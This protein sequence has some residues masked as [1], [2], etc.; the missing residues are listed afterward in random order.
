M[1]K[2]RQY[3]NRLSLKKSL[4]VMMVSGLLIV[5]VLSIGIVVFFD[6]IKNNLD[7]KRLVNIELSEVYIGDGEY[8]LPYTTP[9]ELYAEIPLS[10]SETILYYFSSFMM[11]S[12]PLL[13]IIGGL[14]LIVYS[15]YRLKIAQPLKQLNDGIIEITKQNLDFKLEI[16]SDDELGALCKTFETMREELYQN[17]LLLYQMAQQRQ[18]LNLS[19]SHDLRTPI[20]ILKGYLDFL[21]QNLERL[22]LDT[23][24]KT[25]YSMQKASNRLARYVECIQDI[26]KVEEIAVKK[27]QIVLATLIDDLSADFNTNALKNDKQLIINNQTASPIINSDEEIIFKILENILNNAFRFAR[28]QV[29]ITISEDD[30]CLFFAIKDDGTGFSDQDLQEATKMYYHSNSNQGTFGI[31][32]TISSILSSKLGGNLKIANQNGALVTVKIKKS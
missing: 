10:N 7:S 5:I 25:I 9:V 13:I 18:L 22:P 15:Y 30:N 28:K 3:F 4:V 21:E 20:T 26:H 31:G 17:N 14:A 23:T 27:E 12:G 19:V 8:I 32:L 6:Q 24:K 11:L 29:I 16:N 1:E 2:I